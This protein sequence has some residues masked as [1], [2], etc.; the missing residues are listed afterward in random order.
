MIEE[1]INDFQHAKR[2]ASSRLSIR[3]NFLLPSNK[4]I[5]LSL[6][7]RLRLFAHESTRFNLNH[8]RQTAIDVMEFLLPFRPRIVGGILENYVTPSSSINLHLFAQTPEE[9]S[10]FLADHQISFK[11]VDKRFRYDRDRI[12]YIPVLQLS[13]ED[14][15]I[16]GAIFP[17]KGLRQAPL[18]P[19]HG[20]P[21]KRSTVEQ[22]RAKLFGNCSAHLRIIP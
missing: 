11:S 20:N 5:E 10:L 9:I 8:Y 2:K 21:M 13:F 1:G 7:E 16:E 14:I 18:S 6:R 22:L 3:E 19:V 15:P 12:E 4:E 17:P